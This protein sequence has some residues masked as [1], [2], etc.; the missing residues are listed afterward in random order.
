VSIRKKIITKVIKKWLYKYHFSHIFFYLNIRSSI[1]FYIHLLFVQIYFIL[2]FKKIY[3]LHPSQIICRFR[4]NCFELYVALQYNK[5]L[6]LLFLLYPLTIYTQFS[7]NSFMRNANM[8]PKGSCY[9]MLV[10]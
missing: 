2:G 4:K 6:M 1:F 10:K 9:K 5:I 3:I 8:C 7:F